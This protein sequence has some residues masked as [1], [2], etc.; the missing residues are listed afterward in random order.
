MNTSE[1]KVKKIR[2]TWRYEVHHIKKTNFLEIFSKE[3][4]IYTDTN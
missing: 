3:C 4:F 1:V 2:N